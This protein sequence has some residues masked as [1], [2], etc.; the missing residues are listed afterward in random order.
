MDSANGHTPGDLDRAVELI[1]AVAEGDASVHDVVA[2]L[3]EEGIDSLDVLVSIIARK[4]RQHS[5]SR[6]AAKWVDPRHF[7]IPT[8]PEHAEQIVHQVPHVPFLLNGTLYDP[9]DIRRFDGREL[10]LVATKRH[11]LAF[12]DRNTIARWWEM[13]F[14]Q[15]NMDPERRYQDGG[16]QSVPSIT[17][18]DSEFPPPPP[19]VPWPPVPST[20]PPPKVTDFWEDIFSTF[21]WPDSFSHISLPPNRGYPD[22]TEVGRGFLDLGDWNDEISAVTLNGNWV[23]VLHEHIHFKGRTL[24]ITRD[25]NPFDM[26]DLRRVGFNDMASSIETW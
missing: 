8:P 2:R 6:R 10:H 18:Q 22:L 15:A 21:W 11:L 17:P 1:S 25:S 14:L 12:D 20:D 23:A 16:Y 7:W 13:T 26:R 4:A 9:A 19:P 24:T 3:R 5:Q